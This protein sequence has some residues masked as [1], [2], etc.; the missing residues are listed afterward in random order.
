[1]V[2]SIMRRTMVVTGG[3][4]GIGAGVVRA[5]LD[6]GYDV[7]ASS[8]TI[9][10]KGLFKPSEHLALV[11]GDLSEPHTAAAIVAEGLQRFG[12]ID[13]LVNNAGLY[14]AKRFTEYSIEDLHRLVALNLVGFFHVTQAVIKQMLTQNRGGS[15]VNVTASLVDHPLAGVHASVA[16]LTKGGLQAITRSLSMEYGGQGIRV[17]AIAPGAVDKVAGND[18]HANDLGMMRSLQGVSRI[19]DIVEAIVYLAGAS[20]VTGEIL[21]VN[22]GAGSGKGSRAVWEQP[23]AATSAAG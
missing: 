13:A 19:S 2:S 9:T 16:M 12:S 7:V 22:G 1:M 18:D 11:D 8:R 3:S 20:Q 14:V 6:R 15:I 5:A 10:G 4:Q 21:H 23:S 17:N